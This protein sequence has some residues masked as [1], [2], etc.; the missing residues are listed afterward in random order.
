MTFALYWL[1]PAPTPEQLLPSVDALLAAE[2][3]SA[4]SN[5]LAALPQQPV[6]SAL[7]LDRKET[8]VVATVHTR[9]LKPAAAE[10]L[11]GQLITLLEAL[12]KAHGGEIYS[13][14][15]ERVVA[16]DA[17]HQTLARSYLEALSRD[18][19]NQIEA[20]RDG[21]VLSIVGLVMVVAL[22]VGA[23]QLLPQLNS[24]WRWLI[25]LASAAVIVALIRR[26]WSRR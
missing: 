6:H 5:W 19:K 26:F 1:H 15:L 12:Q 25:A 22:M 21:R 23:A 24:T 14:D 18:A 4:H 20:A 9:G 10:S 13:P 17:D 3:N 7:T 11:F 8:G 16:L 2:I